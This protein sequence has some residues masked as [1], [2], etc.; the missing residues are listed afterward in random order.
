MQA[1]ISDLSSA[2]LKMMEYLMS[3]CSAMPADGYECKQARDYTGASGL[4][5]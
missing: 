1:A 4:A 2:L 5:C 3:G